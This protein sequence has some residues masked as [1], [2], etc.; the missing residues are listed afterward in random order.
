MQRKL[1]LNRRQSYF[2]QEMDRWAS[3]KSK[4]DV[5]DY[6]KPIPI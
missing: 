1:M 6:N 4:Y 2:T 3:V 5:L